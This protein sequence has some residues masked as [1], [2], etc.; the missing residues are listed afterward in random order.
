MKTRRL[1]GWN[2][3][4]LVLAIVILAM[5]LLLPRIVSLTLDQYKNRVYVEKT[6]SLYSWQNN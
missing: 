6:D 4:Y 2:I 5:M 1:L 3:L